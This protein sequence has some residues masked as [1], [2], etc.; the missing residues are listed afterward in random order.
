[1]NS[2]SDG[3]ARVLVDGASGYLGNHVVAALLNRGLVVHALVRPQV[4]D[5]DRE[6]LQASGAQ[7]FAVDLAPFQADM[8]TGQRRKLEEAFAGVTHAVHLIGSIAPAK[9]ENF[10]QLHLEQ[11][12]AF[13]SWCVRAKDVGGFARA[14]MVTAL[15]AEQNA[16]SEYLRSK[17]EGELALLSELEPANIPSS[18]F[19]PSLIV[20]RA[21]GR[22]DSKLVKRYRQLA[23]TRPFVPLIN[24]GRNLVQPVFVTDLAEAIVERLCQRSKLE[25]GPDFTS[26]TF[27][28]G[29]AQPLTMR[30]FVEALMAAIDIKKSFVEIPGPIALAAA[31]LMQRF[32]DVPLLSADQ[33]RMTSFDNICSDNALSKII[34]R[35]PTSLVDALATYHNWDG[36]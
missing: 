24:G 5:S 14:A 18:I 22:R 28:I 13:A 9:A 34:D 26:E 31:N 4:A 10:S 16:A 30:E 21:V 32:Q 23:R 11:S 15:G 35:T 36:D 2:H 12:R 25:I 19:R 8:A 6:F 20:G 29:G 17:R 7:V 33:V 27:E 1:M 3:H